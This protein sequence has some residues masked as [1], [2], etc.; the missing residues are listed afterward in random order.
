MLP[1]LA[2][3]TVTVQS[4][5]LLAPKH[6]DINNSLVIDLIERR[7]IFSSQNDCSIRKTLVENICDFPSVILLLLTFFK[8]LKYLE[9]L[10]KTL[11][12]LL[13]EQIKRTI[14]LSLTG[15]FFA[16]SKNIVQLNKTKDVKIKVRL[17]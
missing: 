1:F 13:G 6:L 8:T 3:N 11:R 17:S 10:C 15:L 12:Q 4:L 16:P 7:Q 2:V 14:Q 9:P 5:K